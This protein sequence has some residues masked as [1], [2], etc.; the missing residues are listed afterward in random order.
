M[1]HDHPERA[2]AVATA[3]DPIF[4]HTSLQLMANKLQTADSVDEMREAFLVFDRDKSGSVTAS[5]LKHVI[6]QEARS[7]LFCP[8]YEKCHIVVRKGVRDMSDTF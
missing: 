1:T 5:E 3:V 2:Q 6:N 4:P 8:S 7:A